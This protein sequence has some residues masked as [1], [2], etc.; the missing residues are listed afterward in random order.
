MAYWR[1]LLGGDL[2]VDFSRNWSHTSLLESF[3]S[4]NNLNP[5]IRHSS[6]NVG[7]TYNFNMTRFN[8][9]DHFMLSGFLSDS[10]VEALMSVILSS[11]T[12]IT[13]SPNAKSLY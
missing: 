13:I 3:C 9:L 6:Y 8:N 5:L 2:N 11:Y 7:Y 12:S 1:L 10:A 4:D